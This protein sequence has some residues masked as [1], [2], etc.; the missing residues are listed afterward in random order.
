MSAC[1]AVKISARDQF[2]GQLLRLLAS[3]C[4]RRGTRPSSAKQLIVRDQ[5]ALPEEVEERI[6][7]DFVCHENDTY[8]N[9]IERNR[10]TPSI[11]CSITSL[12]HNTFAAGFLET[13][14]EPNTD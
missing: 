9:E 6:D 2:V 3:A 11:L 10:E 1:Q 13:G 8:A 14:A 4:Y 5:I 7:G 12:A